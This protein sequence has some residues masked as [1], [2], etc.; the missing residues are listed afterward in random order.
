[1]PDVF[2]ATLGQRPEVITIALDVLLQRACP[3]DRC[4][5]IHTDAVASGISEALAAIKPVLKSYF[6]TVRPYYKEVCFQNGRPLQDVTDQM[7]ADIYYS[8]IIDTLQEYADPAG[9]CHML[10]AGGRKAM[11]IY[12]MLAASILFR[13]NDSVWTLLSDP[14]LVERRGVFHV[15]PAEQH[16]VQLV[17][18]PVLPS[19]LAPGADPHRLTERRSSNLGD[20]LQKLTPKEREVVEAVKQSPGITNEQ[21]A[22]RLGK[23]RSTVESQL[24]KVYDKLVGFFDLS[25]TVPSSKRQLLAQLLNE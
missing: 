8:T 6:P 22:E 5:I 3:I 21:I 17:R 2:F 4:V 16:R 25:D 12:A 20:F 14:P 1:M 7:S 10:V 11:S 23:S 19:R 9:R 15:S 24:E 13:S 18:L